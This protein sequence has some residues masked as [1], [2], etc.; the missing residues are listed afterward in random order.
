VK[1]HFKTKQGIKCFTSKRT[2]ELKGVDPDHSQR[3]LVNTLAQGKTAEWDFF[4]QA[5][6]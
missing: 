5:M 2:T 3:D 6:P 1:L 4:I